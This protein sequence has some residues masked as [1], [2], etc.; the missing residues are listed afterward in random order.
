MNIHMNELHGVDIYDTNK[1]Y[2]VKVWLGGP[3]RNT[4]KG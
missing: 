4:L 1:G 2:K 3:I